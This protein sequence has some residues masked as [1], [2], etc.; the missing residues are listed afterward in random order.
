MHFIELRLIWADNITRTDYKF[1]ILCKQ[2]SPKL[3]LGSKVIKS[4]NNRLGRNANG[5]ISYGQIFNPLCV[6]GCCYQHRVEV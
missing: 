4:V 6:G 1:N 3:I 5:T 2:Y